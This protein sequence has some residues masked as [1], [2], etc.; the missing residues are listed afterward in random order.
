[1]AAWETC[2]SCRGE[3]C[4]ACNWRGEVDVDEKD[5]APVASAARCLELEWTHYVQSG[6]RGRVFLSAAIHRY[7]LAAVVCVLAA[8]LWTL[9]AAA[10]PARP[11]AGGAPHVV[12]R[13]VIELEVLSDGSSRVISSRPVV[14]GARVADAKAQGHSVPASQPAAARPFPGQCRAH[15]VSSDRRCRKRALPGSPFCDSHQGREAPDYD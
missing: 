8:G 12:A 2:Q 14:A 10:A 6:G 15:A 1:M 4:Q 9:N 11:A 13:L 3:G 7:R 5:A